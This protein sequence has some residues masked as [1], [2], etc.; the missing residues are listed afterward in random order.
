MTA[1]RPAA[2][3]AGLPRALLDAARARRQEALTAGFLHDLNGPLNNVNLTLALLDATL[4]RA[5]AAAPGDGLL[6]R[7]QRHVAL[8]QAESLR[9]QQWSRVV[10][11]VL[12]AP[13]GAEPRADLLV[14]L[15]EVHRMV[16]H[17]AALHELMLSV[18]APEGVMVAIDPWHLRL[19]LLDVLAPLVELGAPGTII[20]LEVTAP[21]SRVQEGIAPARLCLDG[22]P[23]IAGD[24]TAALEAAI[25][26]DPECD[27][28]LPSACSAEGHELAEVVADLVAA[29]LRAEALGARITLA[30]RDGRVR[31]ALDLPLASH[32]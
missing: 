1:H 11:N 7:C 31:I 23:A 24:A 29:R 27:A 8:L 17:Q 22:E 3:R 30:H 6:D 18:A 5:R 25:A 2:R 10:G 13:E 20:E 14:L 15:G 26:F 28:D 4:G 12:L 16:R 9:L 32:V 19:L 21:A